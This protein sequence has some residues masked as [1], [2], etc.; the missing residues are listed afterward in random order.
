MRELIGHYESVVAFLSW[1]CE[2]DPY[3]TRLRVERM[4]AEYKLDSLKAKL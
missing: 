2:C 3:N 1:R 4:E